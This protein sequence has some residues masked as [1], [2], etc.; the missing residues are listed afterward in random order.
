[1]IR[2]FMKWIN[3][4]WLIKYS[5]S[6]Y[7]YKG[8]EIMWKKKQHKNQNK[9]QNRNTKATHTKKRGGLRAPQTITLSSEGFG[10][11]SQWEL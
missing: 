10:C 5:E 2:M 8:E 6:A 11:N 3:Q 7:I 4:C 1:M 9:N